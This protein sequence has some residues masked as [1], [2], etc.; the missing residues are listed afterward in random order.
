MQKKLTIPLLL[1][2]ILGLTACGGGSG[3]T[4]NGDTGKNNNRSLS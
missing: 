4:N 2:C 1:S 3:G